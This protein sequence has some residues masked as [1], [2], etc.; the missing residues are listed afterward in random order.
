MVAESGLGHP[1]HPTA[2]AQEKARQAPVSSVPVSYMQGQHLRNYSERTAEGL[3]FSR[4]IIASC[5][6]A[7]QC[8]YLGHG[9]RG[10]HHTCVGTTHSAAGSNRPVTESSSGVRSR[11]RTISNSCRSITATC[12]STKYTPMWWAYTE[13]V[14]MG[15]AYFRDIQN[16]DHFTFFAAMDHVHGDA[17]LIGTTMMKPTACIRR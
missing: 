3:N 17:T 15:A 7:G 12:P 1:W 6:V 2:A 5:E 14:G 8:R 13:S 10:Q 4:Q 11:I 16:E 9:P